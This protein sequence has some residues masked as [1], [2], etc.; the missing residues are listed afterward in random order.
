MNSNSS[1]KEIWLEVN[2]DTCK[3]TRIIEVKNYNLILDIEELKQDNRLISIQIKQEFTKQ[4]KNKLT[5]NP[6]FPANLQ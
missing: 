3:R 5:C 2:Q 4:D 1:N 6:F